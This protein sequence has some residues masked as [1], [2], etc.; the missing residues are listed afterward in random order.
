MRTL[1]DKFPGA[2]NVVWFCTTAFLVLAVLLLAARVRLE[3]M[4]SRLDDLYLAAED[5]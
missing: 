4:R 5:Y 1:G 3:A 2:W